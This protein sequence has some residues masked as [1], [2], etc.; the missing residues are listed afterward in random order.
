M[1]RAAAASVAGALLLALGGCANEPAEERAEPASE[2]TAEAPPAEPSGEKPPDPEAAALAR[3]NAAADHLGSNLR[4][5]LVA[6]LQ[7]GGPAKAVEVCSAE[8]PE[9]ARAA[10]DETG[11]RVGRSSLRLRN[12]ANEP[13]EWVAAWLES[14]GEAPAAEAT[15]FARIE[16]G[17]ARVLRPIPVEGPC[18][19]CHGK[20]V[21]PEVAA[22]LRERYPSDRATGYELG[23]LRGA[24][25]AE[26]EVGEAR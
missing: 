24:L 9:I 25:W 2:E 11:A 19:A 12:P 23:E 17:H 14:T 20:N 1:I 18:L 22:I 4:A 8:A 3:A 13:P 5:R 21:A 6:A 7:E 10:A 26:A 16:D 15:G